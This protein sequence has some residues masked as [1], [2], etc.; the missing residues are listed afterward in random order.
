[1]AVV[2]DSTKSGEFANSFIDQDYADEYFEVHYD[3]A[4]QSAWNALDDD[5]KAMLLVQAA[6]VL[7]SLRFTYVGVR[8]DY[9]LQYDIHAKKV[10]SINHDV[11]P[12]KYSFIQNLQFPRN[13]DIDSQTGVSYIPEDIKIAQCEQAL[14]IKN[15]SETNVTKILGGIRR[16]AV[17]IGG[18]I[19]RDIAYAD[20][21]TQT[22]VSL[23]SLS[24]FAL[25]WVG[26]YLIHGTRLERV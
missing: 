25:Q 24:P 11:R 13:I 3:S 14:A 17:S 22:T 16:E 19:S 12:L 20:N 4:K 8:E 9:E 1:M 18:E 10:L 15:F 7:N 6:S 26:K 21:A 2:I 23:A 5:Q